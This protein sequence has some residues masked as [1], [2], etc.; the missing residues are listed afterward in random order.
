MYSVRTIGFLENCRRALAVAF[1]S[2]TQYIASHSSRSFGTLLAK[3]MSRRY[4][5]Y[6]RELSFFLIFLTEP[7]SVPSEKELG[8]FF[9]LV[10]DSSVFWK[11]EPSSCPPNAAKGGQHLAR[12]PHKTYTLEKISFESSTPSHICGKRYS[13]VSIGDCYSAF[14][15]YS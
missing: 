1:G 2:R 4:L 3:D 11:N 5:A 8:L 12:L 7:Y 14:A 9:P 13:E 15:A 10:V 6:F